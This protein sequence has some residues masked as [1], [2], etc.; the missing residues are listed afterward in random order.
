MHNQMVIF[1]EKIIEISALCQLEL[2]I[3]VSLSR[4]LIK[5]PNVSARKVAASCVAR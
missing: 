2:L 1:N 5:L 3:I 4:K